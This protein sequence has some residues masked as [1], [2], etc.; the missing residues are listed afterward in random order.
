M[1]TLKNTINKDWSKEFYK[2]DEYYRENRR[3]I[4][5]FQMKNEEIGTLL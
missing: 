5:G 3:K 1:K 2:Y 4:E